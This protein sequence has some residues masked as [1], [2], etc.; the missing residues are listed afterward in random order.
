M[1][2]SVDMKGKVVESGDRNCRM[3][4]SRIR[5]EGWRSSGIRMGESKDKDGRQRE[6]L[7]L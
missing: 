2:E 1:E 5:I 4:E 3:E 7:V 6:A